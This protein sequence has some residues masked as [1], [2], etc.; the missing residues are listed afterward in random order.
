[1]AKRD[2][3][4][5]ET[6]HDRLGGEAVGV[7]RIGVSH[8]HLTSPSAIPQSQKRRHT[9]HPKLS[10]SATTLCRLPAKSQSFRGVIVVPEACGSF[11]FVGEPPISEVRTFATV[12]LRAR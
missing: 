12:R 9:R 11:M 2:D 10:T 4:S 3:A 7:F 1:M 6:G 8:A 5:P